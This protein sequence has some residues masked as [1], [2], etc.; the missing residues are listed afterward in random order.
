MEKIYK[1]RISY[2]LYLGIL[3][4]LGWLLGN[5]V[6][7][8][9]LQEVLNTLLNLDITTIFFILVAIEVLFI[10]LTVVIGIIKNLDAEKGLK[11]I[12]FTMICIVIEISMFSIYSLSELIK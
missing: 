3:F 2:L 1:N 4:I 8:N 6:N 10:I 12:F 5:H 9:G 7:I 11:F